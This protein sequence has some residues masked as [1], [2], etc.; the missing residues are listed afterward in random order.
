MKLEIPIYHDTWLDNGVENLYHMLSELQID[1]PELLDV[2]LKEDRLLLEIFELDKFPYYFA[3]RIG[4]ARDRNLFYEKKLDT[5]ETKKTM[6]SFSPLQS[7]WVKNRNLIKEKIYHEDK[8]EDTIISILSAIEKGGNRNRCVL[9][10]RSF[11]RKDYKLKLANYPF[12]TKI[13]SI[14][15]T[16]TKVEKD[17]SLSRWPDQYNDLC[18]ICYAVSTL[19]WSDRGIVYRCHLNE[20]SLMLLPMSTNLKE[21]HELKRHYTTQLQAMDNVSNVRIVLQMKTGEE[22]FRRP[23]GTYSLILAFMEKLTDVAFMET[24]VNSFF[25]VTKRINR[26]WMALEIAEG[27]VKMIKYRQITLSKSIIEMVAKMIQG[28]VFVF[29]DLIEQVNLSPQAKR[30]EIDELKEAMSKSIITDDYEGFASSFL[31]KK[32]KYV[33]FYPKG[34]ESLD[35]LIINW[36]WNELAFT[37]DDLEMVKKVGNIAA[38]VALRDMSVL[39]KMDKV[40]NITDLLD[41]LREISRK[42]VG[43]DEKERKYLSPNSMEQL[44]EKVYEYAGQRSDFKDLKSTL[45]IYSCMEYAK[46]MYHREKSND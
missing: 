28:D 30:E 3:S 40:R 27:N 4:D 36:R 46:D 6:K 16:R 35:E 39:Y 37:S 21:L 20:W 26:D 9:C 45:V 38:K 18:P 2:Q 13:K 44:L 22:K 32:S 34:K 33:N 10:G 1:E 7:K 19:Q 29:K 5:D 8:A 42:I 12:V 14:S 24:Q 23:S 17:G 41:V 43:M 11:G 15:G 25:E 31:P